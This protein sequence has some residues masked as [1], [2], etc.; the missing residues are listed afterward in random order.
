MPLVKLEGV[1]VSFSAAP[2]LDE[3]DFQIDPGERIALVGLNGAGKSTLM[4]LVSG[5]IHAD[6]GLV[7]QDPAIRVAQL[8][9]IL[10]AADQRTVHDVVAGGLAEVLA[11][12]EAFDA[13]S[14]QTDAA[15]LRKMEHLQHQLEARD[16]WHLEQ[17]VETVLDRLGL[18]ANTRMADLSG[19][20]RRRAALGAALVQNPDLLLLDEPTNHL[21]IE[22]IEWLEQMMQEFR[23][24]I[25]FVSHDR[26]L[27]EKL[28]TRIVELDRGN[29]TS[30]PG[31]YNRYLE[32]KEQ[33]LEEEARQNAEFDKK[34]AQ[35]ERW[36]RQGIKAR[37]TRNEGR[38]RAL[39]KMRRERSQRRERQSSA[40]FGLE[41]GQRSGKLVA[42]LKNVSMTYA[43]KPLLVDFSMKVQRGDRIGLIG[44]N[45]SGKSTLLKIILGQLEPDAGE[46]RMGTKLE[47]AYFDQLRG[48]LDMNKS[49]I[50]NVSGG[51]ESVEINGQTKHIIGYLQDFLF[52]PER[53][54]TPV[55][56]LSGGE[57]NRLL[58]ARLFSQPAN[59]LVLDEPT[60]DLDIETLELLEDI[61]LNFDGT[62]LLV[63]H[64]RRFL[65]NVV[66]SSIVFEGGAQVREY[67][68][69]YEDW[70]RQ[71]PVVAA[72]VEKRDE[73]KG[74]VKP[75]KRQSKKLSYKL[76]R[77]L[78]QLP[79]QME[80]VEQSLEALQAVVA[81]PDFYAGGHE[82]VAETLAQMQQQEQQLETLMERW[83]E[84]EAMQEGD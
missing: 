59:V 39:E 31:S 35:E 1:S 81:A 15:S 34:L 30:F 14:H 63:S 76:Q 84:L 9:Q 20:W 37:R 83:M 52:S 16:G 64:D 17:Q 43:D 26:A 33:L 28:A 40:S 46:V 3:I 32:L 41:E 61:L 7:W 23:G 2:L 12:R 5:E 68:G 8:P 42:E 72:A 50:D 47:V 78:D 6:S 19:G 13:L 45:G 21:D 24:A 74:E 11:L 25:L 70:L 18:D 60:N 55:K 36:I 38:V 56:A 67:V 65:D 73:R 69:G 53:A 82:Q 57:C 27:V 4:K 54:R 75:Q 10:P 22:T 79:E 29:L 49:V 71:R 77:E 80:A 48:Q 44:P 51:R 66:T 58:L 62:I